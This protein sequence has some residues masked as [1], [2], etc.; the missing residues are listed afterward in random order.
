[1]MLSC[2]CSHFRQGLFFGKEGWLRQKHSCLIKCWLVSCLCFPGYSLVVQADA[3]LR[4]E[5]SLKYIQTKFK[6]LF[7]Y[8]YIYSIILMLFSPRYPVNIT[9]Q[10][11]AAKLS[12]FFSCIVCQD[13]AL[14]FFLLFGVHISKLY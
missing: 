8:I 1:M 7:I 10:G 9:C 2:S 14:F 11:A 5:R 4:V 12:Y 3:P 6:S 13:L